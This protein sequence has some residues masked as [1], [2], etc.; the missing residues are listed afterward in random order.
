MKIILSKFFI[1]LGLA[2]FISAASILIFYPMSVRAERGISRAESKMEAVLE[3]V[4]IETFSSEALLEF[5][6]FMAEL[7]RTVDYGDYKEVKRLM[8]ESKKNIKKIEKLIDKLEKDLD[9]LDD[10]YDDGKDH[11]RKHKKEH[12]KHK[13]KHER[14]HY[15]DNDGDDHHRRGWNANIG[16]VDHGKS[17]KKGGIGNEG[18]KISTVSKDQLLASAV[19]SSGYYIRP[20]VGGR[21]SQGL[22]GRNA[23][24]FAAPTG[25]PILASAAGTVV[26]SGRNGGYGNL[27]VIEHN[28]GTQ[29]AYAHNSKNLVKQGDVVEQGDIIGRVGSTGKS[30]GPHVHFEIRGAKNP[31]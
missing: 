20:I 4:D 11:E 2:A 14:D 25:T 29:T 5:D 9:N 17:H 18:D 12:K 28:N 16:H 1:I 31:F 8:K 21:R 15:D 13:E 30:T 22:H 3:E 23:V 10:D 24:D 7:E 19:I 26:F 27:I 6:M